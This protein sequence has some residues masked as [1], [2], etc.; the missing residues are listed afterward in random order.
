[1]SEIKILKEPLFWL[2][3]FLVLLCLFLFNLPD[4]NLHL[5]FCDVGQGDATLIVY[6]QNQ[7]LV[8]GGPDQKVLSCLSQNLP[9]Y[10]RR[11]EMVVLTHPEEDHF[12]GLIDV[13]KR[14][15]VRYFVSNGIKKSSA[16]FAELEKIKEEKKV[17]SVLVKT[18][19]QIKIGLLFFSVLWPEKDYIQT[20]ELNDSTVVLKL[21]FGDFEALLT[22]DISEKVEN[23]LNL[24]KVEVLKVAHHGSKFSTSTAFLNLVKPYLAVISVGENR[25]GHPTAE[26]LER[27]KQAG[28][29]ILRTDQIGTIEIVSDGRQWYTR[30]H[31]SRTN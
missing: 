3:L 8:D 30:L 21:S 6:K 20:K 24:D 15:D 11:I 23:L 18:G 5:V 25:F 22:G 10:D 13:L 9:F 12:F 19:D 26:V 7:I 14:Y 17:L 16:S 29:K 27:L 1:M 31:G 28:A 4:N 2:S